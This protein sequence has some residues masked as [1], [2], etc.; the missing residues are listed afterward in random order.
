MHVVVW[1][2]PCE[3]L[4]RCRERWLANE[5]EDIAFLRLTP[6]RLDDEAVALTVE[7]ESGAV[8]RTAVLRPSDQLLVSNGRPK[9]AR[10]LTKWLVEQERLP[11]GLFGPATA[12]QE[13]ARGL[14]TSTKARYTVAKEL[15]HL[16]LETLVTP[17]ST[18]GSLREAAP[19]DAEQLVRHR[20][21]LQLELNTLRPFDSA[22]SVAEDLQAGRLHVWQDDEG[23]VVSS[24]SLYPDRVEGS[25]YLDHVY[26]VEERRGRGF[27]S[28]LV[29]ATCCK[30]VGQG[31]QARL[32]VDADN[33]PAIAVY[34]RM[35]FAVDTKMQNLR[36]MVEH[37]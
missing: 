10:L 18:S 34:R 11:P 15:L 9:D 21:Q 1:S 35:G 27:A 16:H 33:A 36:R 7:E 31:L 17:P 25:V 13:I 2:D 5:A 14:E 29:H 30:L 8:R 20:E 22:A 26:T 3:F 32:S 24:V 28:A 12:C 19:S 6:E 4:E 37:R 23:E